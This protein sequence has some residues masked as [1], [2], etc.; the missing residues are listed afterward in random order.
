MSSNGSDGAIPS[1]LLSLGPRTVERL[2][3]FATNPRRTVLGLIAAAI[4]GWVLDGATLVLDAINLLFTGGRR[5][6]G[7]ADIPTLLANQLT[8]AGSFVARPILEFASQL[9]GV[10]TSIISS[11]GMFGPIVAAFMGAVAVS[12]SILLIQAIGATLVNYFAPF[13]EPVVGRWL[14]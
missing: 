11:A 12:V 8:T 13:L 14:Q 6:V 10:S 4:V 1:Y 7:F 2:K 3:V 5:A 9:V